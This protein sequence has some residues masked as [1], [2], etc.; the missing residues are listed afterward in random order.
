MWT[1]ISK[2]L[3]FGGRYGF[4]FLIHFFFLIM[5][6]VMFKAVKSCVR[7]ESASV[8]HGNSNSNSVLL[9]QD[10][11]LIPLFGLI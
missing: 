2:A 6:K 11:L 9:T 1:C 3:I 5:R 8:R 7:D 10:P 4:E